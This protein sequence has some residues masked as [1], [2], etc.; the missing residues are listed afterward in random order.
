MWTII[1]YILFIV[2]FYILIKGADLL[3]DGASSIAKRFGIS[4][5]V[6]GLTIVAFGTSMPELIVNIF[7]S[8]QDNTEIAIG[9]ILGSNIA[10]ILLILGV[11]ALIYPL[12]VKKNTTWK[13]IPLA[14]LAVIALALMA[15]DR[16][17]DGFNFSLLTRIDGLILLSFFAI[18]L[19]YTHGISKGS[20]E[21][22][23]NIKE[24]RLSTSIL[25]IISGLACLTIGG[26]W[27]VDGAVSIA[28]SLGISQA[29]IGLTIVAIGTSLP[30]L[31]T[32]AVAAYKKKADIAVGNI[33]GS[34][35]FNI[36]W[37][38]GLSATIKP[39][40]FTPALNF[41]ILM[42]V[43]A[44]LLLFSAM[45]IGKKRILERWQGIGF[46]IIYLCYII[47]LIYRG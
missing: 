6:I 20:K 31:A 15:N 37:I 39:L 18:F 27:I 24:R 29:L 4:A 35:I 5:I 10:N 8:I 26:K 23:N 30:E 41:D 38:L 47:F 13:E 22:T 46:I 32:S 42:T 34:N 19:Y 33:V 40:P 16:L 36:F 12:A 9:N 11:S 3:V 43:I 1:T 7:A 28:A 14:L 2:G 45:F 17:V 44:T 25:M 21:E